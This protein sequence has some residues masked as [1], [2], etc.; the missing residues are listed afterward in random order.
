MSSPGPAPRSL[1][2]WWICLLLLLATT[3]N[4]M[5]RMALTQTSKRIIDYFQLTKQQYGYIESAFN[6]AFA[7]GALAIGWLVDR[8][9]PRWIYP[10]IVVLWSLAGFAAG[11]ATSFLMLLAC[12]FWLGLF[13]AGNW[14]CG[15]LTVKRVLPPEER[16]LGNGMFH[17]GTAL[18]AILM[19]QVVILCLSYTDPDGT[20][21][22]ALS[23]QLPFRVVG[24]LG[25]AWAIAWMLSVKAE[26]VRPRDL[27]S[28]NVT[29]SYWAIWTQRRFWLLLLVVVSI[30]ITWR[31]FGTWLPMF[32]REAKGY[33]ETRMNHLTS[34]FFL[35]ADLGSISMGFLTLRLA[36]RGVPLH[37]ARLI[38]FLICSLMTLCTGLVVALPPGPWLVA[39]LMALGFAA[40]GLFPTYFALSQEIS[41]QHQ[42]KVTGT[43]GCL[44]GLCLAVMFP[45]QGWLVD[46]TNSYHLALGLAGLPPIL[47]LIGV[48]LFWNR[49]RP[50]N[51]GIPSEITM[52]IR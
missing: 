21:N 44:N 49:G 2:R 22:D 18:G 14:P 9:G 37:R 17:S 51:P 6:V 15:I 29:E 20:G 34:A 33:P 45:V 3:L 13:E 41:T 30:N 28:D 46:A 4:Y 25:I 27:P 23:W 47:A 31:S 8:R 16:S 7:I 35:A 11:F 40:L 43:L 10:A 12:R 1:F 24:V 38:C 42:G 50:E 39:A 32:L 26:H 19:P 48:G 36:R 52:R 5:D